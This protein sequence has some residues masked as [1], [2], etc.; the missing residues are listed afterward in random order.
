MIDT[1]QWTCNPIQ[2]F[3]CASLTFLKATIARDSDNN[4]LFVPYENDSIGMIDLREGQTHLFLPAQQTRGMIM[5]NE[6]SIHT[7]CI[8]ILFN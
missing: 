7:T 3:E 8:T 1:E 6:G 5:A 4:V 2:Q